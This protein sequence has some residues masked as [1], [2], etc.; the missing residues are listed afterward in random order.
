MADKILIV[1]DEP[2]IAD[3]VSLYLQNENFIVFKFYNAADA[4]K[5][6]QS[7]TLDL[8]I[9]DVMLPDMNGFQLCQK[10]REK[11]QYPVIM[12]TAKG[13]EIDKMQYWLNWIL[14][15]LLR[16]ITARI[17]FILLL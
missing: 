3:L 16:S 9:L 10:I 12:L 11:Y 5:C 14:E 15:M 13:E 1:D 6:V 17:K 7:E 2:E 8:A 4:L